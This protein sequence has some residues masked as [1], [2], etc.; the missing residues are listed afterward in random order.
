[1]SEQIAMIHNTRQ[2]K[3][4]YK[5]FR[6]WRTLAREGLLRDDSE[7]DTE[8]QSSNRDSD[9]DGETYDE[10]VNKVNTLVVPKPE[11]RRFATLG[12]NELA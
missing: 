7:Q 6:S 3:R 8:A 4:L 10:Q 2:L 11:R 9:E 1:M 12:N 5:V